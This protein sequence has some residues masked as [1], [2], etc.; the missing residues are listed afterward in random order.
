MPSMTLYDDNIVRVSNCHFWEAKLSNRT[1][2]IDLTS[3]GDISGMMSVYNRNATVSIELLDN[4]CNHFM[5]YS[6][7]IN[8]WEHLEETSYG[9]RNIVR[10]HLTVR[11]FQMMFGNNSEE[12]NS[13]E[14]KSD[15][16]KSPITES[17]KLML[18]TM[19]EEL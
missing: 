15:Y 18:N 17:F 2:I 6:G 8:R 3:D 1:L 5:A 16:N 10:F 9:S 19:V 4:V 14:L 11:D 12:R 7:V 13:S